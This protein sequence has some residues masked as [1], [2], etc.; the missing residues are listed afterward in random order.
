M[1][2][3][4]PYCAVSRWPKLLESARPKLRQMSPANA[5]QTNFY[6]LAILGGGPAGLAAAFTARRNACNGH[7]QRGGRLRAEQAVNEFAHR[8]LSR[9]FPRP[10]R[11][12]SGAPRRSGRRSALARNL[13]AAELSAFAL[14][15]LP[16]CAAGRWQRDFV[17]RL[18]IAT[19]VGVCGSVAATGSSGYRPPAGAGF[20]YGGGA[21][22]A[23][24]PC[25]GEDC[26]FCRRRELGGPS[27]MNFAK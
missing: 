22:D 26:V 14:R 21:T 5:R 25:K 19:G 15:P 18:M 7:D 4:I 9:I 6:D 13:V 12:R 1:R 10:Q 8:K 27:R 3:A 17:P 2:A 11:R 24:C 16:H 20:Y 23:I